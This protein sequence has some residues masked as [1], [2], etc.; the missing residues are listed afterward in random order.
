MAHHPFNWKPAFLASLR[1]VPVVSRACEAVGIERSTAYRARESDEQLAKDWDDA[2]ETGIDRAEQEAFRRA[3]VGF[4]EPL[5]YQGQ[6][7]WLIEHYDRATGEVVGDDIAQDN[8]SKLLSKDQNVRD[9]ARDIGWRYRLDAAGQRIPV[10]V[11]KHSD[12][13]LSLF[14][15]GRRKKIYAERTEITGADGG[16]VRQVDETARSA[17]VAQ[18]LAMAQAR[19]AEHDDFGDLA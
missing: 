6:V 19:K 9:T 10:T 8:S 1:E 2:M 18:L 16:P 5:T 15:K 4:E 7:T 14:L 17:R 11:R 3:V 13:L 12:A